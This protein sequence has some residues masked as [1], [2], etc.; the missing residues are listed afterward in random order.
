MRYG[1]FF[2]I[3]KDGYTAATIELA[4]IALEELEKKWQKQYP[5]AV[6]LWRDRLEHL[7]TFFQFTDEIRRAV[8]TT[9]ALEFINNSIRK[10]IKNKRFFSN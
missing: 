8:Y 5:A 4:L 3:A 6:K 10:V 7:S 1:F 2:E 9:N